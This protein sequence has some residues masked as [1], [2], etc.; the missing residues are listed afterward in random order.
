MA[1]RIEVLTKVNDTR[2]IV[3]QKKL[4]SLGFSVESAKVIE[5]YTIN[6]D[7]KEAKLKLIAEMLSSPVTQTYL[8]DDYQQEVDFDFSL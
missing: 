5:V 6:K 8:I 2:S 4:N 3:M 1:H 7:F